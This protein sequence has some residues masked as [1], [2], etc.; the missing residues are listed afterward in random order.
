MSFKPNLFA[1]NDPTSTVLPALPHSPSENCAWLFVIVSP[2]AYCVVVP[3]RAAYSHSA[4]V[5]RRYVFPV[6]RDSQARYS[7]ASSHDTLITGRLPLPQPLS[8]GRESLPQ[9]PPAAQ[10]SHSANV[11]SYLPTANGL[12]IV[13]L[14]CGPSLKYM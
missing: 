4:S 10:A 14:C 8:S 6:L 3:A 13:T 2:K 1:G 5:S 9:P 11:T 12:A 7:L